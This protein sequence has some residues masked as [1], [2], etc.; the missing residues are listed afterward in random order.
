MI[1]DDSADFVAAARDL[2]ERQG[3]DVVGV[4]STGDEALAN[5]RE[6]RPD[7]ALIDIDL[8]EESGIDLAERLSGT[9]G[10]EEL[11]L[12]L[13]STYSEKDFVDVVATSPAVGF[14]TKSTLSA[15]AIRR[16]L[17]EAAADTG[18]AT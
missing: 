12:V 3:L 14:L 5:A 10:L 1:V 16:L 6:A 17:G 11:P 8:G 9:A 7:V 18:S 15:S 4:A 13:I 2:L